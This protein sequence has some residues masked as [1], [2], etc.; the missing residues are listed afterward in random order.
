MVE[1]IRQRSATIAVDFTS[2]WCPLSFFD[3]AVCNQG[4]NA[5]YGTTFLLSDSE[6]RLELKPGE[7][8]KHLFGINC[9]FWIVNGNVPYVLWIVN[10]NVPYV[11]NSRSLVY[12]VLFHFTLLAGIIMFF[13][14]RL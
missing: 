9:Y 6:R 14:T 10:G 1:E 5:L 7:L 2:C 4:R 8:N 11:Q 13:I 12:S 3:T